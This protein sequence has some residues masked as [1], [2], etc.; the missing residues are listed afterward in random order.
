L[1]HPDALERLSTDQA[2]IHVERI[3]GAKN[4]SNDQEIAH[5]SNSYQK[6][7]GPKIPRQDDAYL[8]ESAVS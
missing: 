8:P 1:P 6:A 5:L 3:P 4:R 2:S 7:Q